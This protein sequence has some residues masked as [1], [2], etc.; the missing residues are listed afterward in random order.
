MSFKYLRGGT[1][2]FLAGVIGVLVVYL[3]IEVTR[4]YKTRVLSTGLA[5]GSDEKVLLTSAEN[6]QTDVAAK[7]LA[8]EAELIQENSQQ[9][10]SLP[11]T[12]DAFEKEIFT[13]INEE[14]DKIL[15]TT[16]AEKESSTVTK[17]ALKELGIVVQDKIAKFRAAASLTP[18]LDA[19]LSELEFY[20]YIQVMRDRE[21]SERAIT[22]MPN[23]NDKLLSIMSYLEAFAPLAEHDQLRAFALKHK[24]WARQ[25]QGGYVK[26][27]D[28]VLFKVAPIGQ[29]L[30]NHF[31][32][33]QSIAGAN[34][35]M[36]KFKG[37]VLLLDFWATWC[38][39]CLAE[40]PYHQEAY[41]K[42]H[43]R[44]FA[45][46]Y[47]NIDA[48]EQVFKDFLQTQDMPWHH[49]YS[50]ANFDER[51]ENLAF[52]YAVDRLPASY[53][54]SKDGVVLLR[55]LK[56]TGLREALADLF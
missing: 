39:P 24:A 53:L 38:A 4:G 46:I 48:T 23:G 6:E 37:K 42:Y 44:G 25:L 10:N 36:E 33:I 28:Y 9:P 27:I 16:E 3:G 41:Y 47:V 18:E 17:A 43:E 30:P 15:V 21:A 26:Q 20:V 56:N 52:Q 5:A 35:D 8:L 51:K 12:L 1:G 2:L 40:I 54:I 49:V 34:L 32:G 29:K 31:K 14:L 11:L 55:D 50:G 7:L 13:Y 45:I 19:R 22:A